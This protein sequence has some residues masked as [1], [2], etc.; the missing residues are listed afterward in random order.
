MTEA[1]RF[2]NNGGEDECLDLLSKSILMIETRAERIRRHELA[3]KGKIGIY[4][5]LIPRE[6]VLPVYHG[7]K[8]SLAA[9]KKIT[10]MCYLEYKQQ[11]AME[12]TARYE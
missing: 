9:F 12:E 5:N 3:E 11:V 4:G 10:G 6:E 1:I 7:Y 8:D 2:V